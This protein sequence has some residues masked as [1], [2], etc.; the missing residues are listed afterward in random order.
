VTT[1]VVA[2]ARAAYARQ[3]WRAAYSALEPL[4]ADLG[5]DDLEVLGEA[6]W[7]LGDT[8]TSMAVAED[9]YQ[10]LLATGARDEA[11]D[12]AQRLTLSWAVRGD[13]SVATAWLNRAD[14]LLRD[15]PRGPLHARQGYLMVSLDL[16]LTGD[17]AEAET[18][19]AELRDVARRHDDPA[20]ACFALVLEGMAAVRRGRT[21]EG[22]A[23]LDEAMLP[24]L[25][26]RVDA[27][28]AGDIYCTTIHLCEELADLARMRQWTE[29]LA[30]WSIPLS[31]TFMYAH[32]T[33]VHELQ[34]VSAE[35][36][37]DQVEA[38]LG[39][40]RD[41]LVG[42]HGW[43]SG[44]ASYE[45]GEIRRLR[46]DAAGAR[47]A[48]EHG[49]AFGIDPQPGEALLQWAE[50]DSAGALSA[51]RVSLAGQ[52]QLA[53]ARLLLATVQLALATGD[54]GAA[55]ALTTELVDTA[56]YY[57]TPGLQARA[58]QARAAL[59][60]ADGR[61]GDAVPELERAAGIYR[62]QRYRYAGAVVHEQLARAHRDLGNHD[63]ADAAEATAIAI[64]TQL[65]AQADLDRLAPRTLPGGLTARE[66]EVL[67]CVTSGASNREIAEHLVISDKTVSRHLANIFTKVGVTTRTAAAAW[68]REHGL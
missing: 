20:L 61:P 48:Y 23:A 13:L 42:S 32:I 56:D 2:E 40:H 63:R 60:L 52:G 53:R 38:E 50:G 9:V 57:G 44:V 36:R 11:A 45:L 15:L 30:R 66:V 55:G 28:W 29:S 33:R 22:F 65:G 10:R 8:P 43:L 59:A 16:D 17:A 21:V 37:W 39:P 24:V 62:D 4:Q 3:D 54:R 64:Y 18:A 35:G 46:G 1:T 67:A 49:R 5:T 41:S 12:R 27:L 68:A 7:W 34:V 51:L 31:R 14:R 47:A 6:A 58:V 26:G 25:A 19:A